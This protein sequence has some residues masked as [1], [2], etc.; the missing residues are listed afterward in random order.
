MNRSELS[1]EAGSLDAPS[2]GWLLDPID[3]TDEF[4]AGGAAPGRKCANIDPP[5]Y[6]NVPYGGE[7]PPD[8]T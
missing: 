3:G 6:H 4:L 8:S 1:G 5:Y 7:G 2:R